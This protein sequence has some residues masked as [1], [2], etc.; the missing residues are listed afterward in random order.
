MFLIQLEEDVIEKEKEALLDKNAKAFYDDLYQDKYQIFYS[1]DSEKSCLLYEAL[2]KDESEYHSLLVFYDKSYHSLDRES[3]DAFSDVFALYL[4]NVEKEKSQEELKKIYEGDY[5]LLLPLS[6]LSAADVIDRK[7]QLSLFQKLSEEMLLSFSNDT[8][9][10]EEKLFV[11]YCVDHSLEGKHL[12]RLKTRL[13][14]KDYFARNSFDFVLKARSGGRV[15]FYKEEILLSKECLREEDKEAFGELSRWGINSEGRTNQGEIILNDEGFTSFLFALKG[16][17][18][19]LDGKRILISKDIS[20]FQLQISQTGEFFLSPSIRGQY[21]FNGLSLALLED[22]YNRIFLFSFTDEKEMT[23]IRF[24]LLHPDFRYD[25]FQN[26]ISQNILPVLSGNVIIDKTYEE[27]HPLKKEEI[28]YYITY[29]EKDSLLFKTGYFKEDKEVSEV[30]FLS[31]FVGEKKYNQFKSVLSFLSLPF[32]GEEKD[33][34]KILAFLKMDLFPLKKV[35]TVFLSEDLSK[36]KIR[37]I[38]KIRVQLKNDIDWLD[39]EISSEEYTKEELESILLAYRKKKKYVRLKDSFILMDDPSSS[40]FKEFVDD[41]SLSSLTKDDVKPY[42]ALKLVGYEDE[43][44]FSLSEEVKELF[45]E[46]KNFKKEKLNLREDIAKELRPYQEDG[47]KWMSVLSR[48][49]LCGILADDMGLGKTLEMIALLSLSKETRPILIVTPKS[50]IYNWENEFQKWNRSQKVFVIDGNKTMRTVT[51]SQIEE[52]KKEVFITSYES[53]RNDLE[54]Y[55]K[56]HFSYLILDEGQNIANVYARKTRAVKEIACDHKFVLTG[57]PIQNSLVDLWSIFDFLMPGYLSSYKQFCSKFSKISIEDDE[58]EILMKKIAPFVLKRTKKE[59]LKDLPDKEEQILMVNMNEKQRQFYQAMIQTARNSL[60][61]QQS[62]IV[63]LAQITRLREICVDPKMVSDDFAED[64]I[65]LSTCLENVKTA[66]NSGHKV[67]VF[68]SFVQTLL[69]FEKMLIN[70]NI[71][72][73]LICGDTNAKMRIQFADDFNYRDDCKVMLV[74]LKAGGTGLNL[75][76]GDIVILLDPWWNL[77]SEVQ[78]S[79]R[80]HR[81]GQKRKVTVLKM[82]CKDSIEEKVLELQKKKKELSSIIPDSE[83]SISS[84]NS[85]DLRFL[86]S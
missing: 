51:L 38:G 69:H 10:I 78:A 52:G 79:D 68:S 74:S 77:A 16:R 86:L 9:K 84:I 11:T 43:F 80:A 1:F 7:N 33:Q 22:E 8:F 76:G 64:S 2:K 4:H 14:G 44:S 75:I 24:M 81:L 29:S 34:D 65:K 47:V 42:E 55:E 73:H 58:K 63:V 30:E 26:E 20:S 37:G 40:S 3:A 17:E 28:R 6:T 46:I 66:I 35:S 54:E 61:E 36:K 25:L 39:M 59:V 50:L 15:A 32:E 67:I 49:N 48:H 18:I 60:K 72:Y 41:F 31:S 62:K 5:D 85:D 12:V 70:Q 57:T 56:Y 83:D 53:L 82:I 13:H 27:K 23:M 71:N 45:D 19:E 21:F